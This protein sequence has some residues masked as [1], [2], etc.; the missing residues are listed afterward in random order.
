M[1]SFIYY[2]ALLDVYAFLIDVYMQYNLAEF[3]E[4]L[5][6]MGTCLLEKTALN[7][8]EDSGT[9]IKLQFS[10]HMSRHLKTLINPYC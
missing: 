8:D 6:E 3:A 9:Y 10:C 2:V 1:H 4:A 5:D 7:E